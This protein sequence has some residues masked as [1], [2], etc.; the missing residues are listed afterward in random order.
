MTLKKTDFEDRDSTTGIAGGGCV[1]RWWNS[2]FRGAPIVNSLESVDLSH[3]N[4]D[5]G[6]AV[7]RREHRAR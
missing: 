6:R 1:L 3:L 7:M 2:A 4:A 5:G